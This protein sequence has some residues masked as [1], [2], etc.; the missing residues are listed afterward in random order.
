MHAQHERL[1]FLLQRYTSKTLTTPEQEE[2]TTMLLQDWN[3]LNNSM[4]APVDWE[5][6]VQQILSESKTKPVHRIHF[7][8]TTW[9]KYAAAILIILSTVAYLWNTQK[10]KVDP[11]V[12]HTSPVPMQSDV[13]PGGN[14]AALIL[15]NGN[16]IILDDAASGAIAK[17]GGAEIT[18][19]EQGQINYRSPLT[20]HRSPVVNNTLSTPRGGQY[21]LH[22]PDGSKVW[23]NAAS[24]ITYPTA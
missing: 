16:T 6:M 3:Q 5:R 8:K 11:S 19:T 2:L 17:D 23:L 12:S 21:Q 9:F 24:S 7:L 13:A 18:K 22:L 14:K 1:N 4:S 20:A 15:S 10:E